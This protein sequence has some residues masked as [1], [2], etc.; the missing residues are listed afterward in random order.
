MLVFSG[1]SFLFLSKIYKDVSNIELEFP[2]CTSKDSLILDVKLKNSSPPKKKM[3]NWNL[4]QV[5]FLNYMKL[6]LRLQ[7][8]FN[9]I[10][11]LIFTIRQLL[12]LNLPILYTIVQIFTLPNIREISTSL[13]FR[14]G[15]N[16]LHSNWKKKKKLNNTL[17][18]L[19]L[20]PSHL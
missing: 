10:I 13:T 2:S 19:G 3:W 6:L 18:G 14:K 9:E 17:W 20:V 11:I 15:E 4:L 1:W 5:F 7:L 8:I 16:Y 12:K